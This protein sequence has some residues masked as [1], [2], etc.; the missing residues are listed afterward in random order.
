M[1]LSKV[2]AAAV[3]ELGNTEWPPGSNLNPYGK[4]Y[5]MDGQPW[6]VIWLWY[7]FREAGESM[8]FFGGAKTASCG[9]LLKWYQAQ[10]LTAPVSEVQPGDIVILN[11]HGTKATEHCG[12]VVDVGLKNGVY[13][14]STVEGNTSP[15]L[16]GSQNNGGCV[17]RKE[18]YIRQV[19]AVCRPQYTEEVE[20]VDDIKGHWAEQAI[21]RVMDHGFMRGFPDGSFRPDQAVTRAELATIL[22]RLELEGRLQKGDDGK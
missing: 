2:I 5:G 20:P 14:V 17:A 21:R 1:S 15:G 3:G 18:R 10:G 11:F 12:L 8:A 4:A 19:I 13:T 22:D 9:T 7:I 16:E 6:C